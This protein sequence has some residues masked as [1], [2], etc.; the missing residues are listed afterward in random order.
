MTPRTTLIDC[1]PGTDDAIALWLALASPELDVRLVTVAGGNV[2]LAATT[3]NARAIIGLT[4]RAIPVVAGA[5]RSLMAPFRSETAVH[6]EDGLGG[7]R[8]P[9]GPPLSPGIAADAIRGLLRAAPAASVTVIGL[10]PVTNLALAFAT[11]PALVDR[12]AEVVLMSGAWSEGNI[13]PAAEFNA[14]N[15]PEALA[16][17][18][19]LGCRLTMATLD[20]TAQAFVTPAVVA[21]LAARPGG[22]C[23]QATLAI[24]RALPPSRR[25]GFRGFPLHDP[26]AVAWLLAPGLFGARDAQAE[27]DCSPGPGRGRTVIDRWQRLGR[28]P[29]LN[30]LETLDAPGFFDLLAA[31]IAGLP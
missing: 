20:L 16:I 18:L 6:G 22:A 1:D 12:V 3:A 13:T 23:W 30:L 19:G 4:G 9:E 27:M 29:N 10:G 28:P 26:C 7:V 25:M 14:W 17:L 5:E 11:E 2:G 8:L 31:R 15:D 24:L 21:A